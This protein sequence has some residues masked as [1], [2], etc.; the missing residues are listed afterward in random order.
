MEKFIMTYSLELAKKLEDAGYV[1]V[2]ENNGV[3]VFINNPL[4][5]FNFSTVDKSC[6]QLTDTLFI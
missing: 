1:S 2:S 5:N 3:Y 6:Y 4:G